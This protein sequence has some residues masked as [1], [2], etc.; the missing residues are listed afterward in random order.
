LA[1]L[2]L[3]HVVVGR[4]GKDSFW[5]SVLLSPFMVI[6]KNMYNMVSILFPLPFVKD[7]FVSP[8]VLMAYALLP[9]ND[10]AYCRYKFIAVNQNT[11]FRFFLVQKL[12]IVTSF[13][14]P[15][16]LLVHMT[17]NYRGI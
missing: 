13:T 7:A 3:I 1:S 14:R 16:M 9:T 2:T 10:C 8:G 15:T 5:H 6:V 11:S 4:H 17:M 12:L